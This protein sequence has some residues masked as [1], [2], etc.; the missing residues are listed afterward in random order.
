MVVV[1]RNNQFGL[2]VLSLR[3]SGT[4]RHQNGTKGTK[5]S[6]GK[7]TRVEGQH[8]AGETTTRLRTALCPGGGKGGDTHS[9]LLRVRASSRNQPPAF[10]VFISF[11][12]RQ[13]P[14]SFFPPGE[15]SNMYQTGPYTLTKN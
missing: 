8:D 3:S 14:L 15:S 5:Q 2:T 10:A 1:W 11:Q 7:V 4:Q 13:N 6:K 12:L 9:Q